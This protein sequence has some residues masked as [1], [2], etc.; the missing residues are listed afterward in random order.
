ME[1]SD[2]EDNL[3]GTLARS[4][5][6]APL[7]TPGDPSV[8]NAY[9]NFGIAW[10]FFHEVFNRDSIDNKGGPLIGIVNYGFYF[11]NATWSVSRA[12]MQHVLIFGNGWDN[13]PWN[14]GAARKTFA[15]MFGGFVGSLEVVVHEMMHGITRTHV[16]FKAM[17]QPGALNEHL[18]DVF[19]VMAEQWHKGQTVEEADWL[20]GEDC[21]V[22]EKKGLAL[23]SIINPGTAY[24]FGEDVDD[25]NFQGFAKDPQRQHWLDMFDGRE[26][27]FGVHINS[28]IPNKAFYL[29]AK[30]FGGKSWERAGQIW[31]AALTSETSK[32]RQDCRFSQWAQYTVV[33]AKN[34][35]FGVGASEVVTK[36]WLDV[37]V[38]P[39]A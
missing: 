32:V 5:G 13:D 22:P 25:V 4:E 3:P 23:R 7:N 17:D 14:Q 30:R 10:T 6:N 33:A 38:K 15:G 9:D 24:D 31:Y 35:R 26:D 16:E 39:R 27:N 19:G 29:V 12:N 1:F 2:H 34:P 21:L 28:G 37:G 36:A 11:P 20:I 8:D 18:S